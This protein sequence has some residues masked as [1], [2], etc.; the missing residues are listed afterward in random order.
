MGFDIRKRKLFFQLDLEERDLPPVSYVVDHIDNGGFRNL[1]NDRIR[2][3]MTVRRD[4]IYYGDRECVAYVRMSKARGLQIYERDH[5]E[6]IVLDLLR[7]K[8][9]STRLLRFWETVPLQENSL[10]N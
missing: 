9:Q 7:R 5:C 8:T 6:L 4:H 2:T 1:R 10:R 3:A